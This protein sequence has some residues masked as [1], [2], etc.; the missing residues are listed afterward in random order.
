MLRE[1]FMRSPDDFQRMNQDY[2]N[3]L[4]TQ[5]L[6]VD[7]ETGYVRFKEFN[8]LMDPDRLR[9]VTDIASHV[10]RTLLPPD[11]DRIIT[12]VPTRG[13]PFAIPVGINLRN[14]IALAARLPMNGKG[15]GSSKVYAYIDSNDGSVVIGNVPSFTN[16][17]ELYEHRYEINMGDPLVVFDDVCARAEAVEAIHEGFLSLGIQPELY[18][19]ILAKRLGALG[20]NGFEGLAAKDIPAVALTYLM[21][22]H[23]HKG[24]VVPNE[25]LFKP[26]PTQIVIPTR[27]APMHDRFVAGPK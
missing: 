2:A 24:I 17:R 6:V 25:D 27:Y 3:W 5:S 9:D 20:Q 10:V 11:K 7:P 13:I 16:Q 18:V 21:G 4:S 22:M 8:H 1:Q 19:F 12:G 23:D 15:D 14:R 26:S